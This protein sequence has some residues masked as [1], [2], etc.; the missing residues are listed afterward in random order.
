VT[1]EF[2]GAG[3]FA[4][5]IA[6]AYGSKIKLLD[7]L[8]HATPFVATAEATTGLPFISSIPQIS[9]DRPRAA[10]ELVAS[11]LSDREALEETS[12]RLSRELSAF[13]EQERGSWGR[14]LHGLRAHDL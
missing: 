3:L 12:D 9:L 7:C 11:L 8:T 10:A 13:I 4:A 2:V 1:R 6:N 14:L 5:P